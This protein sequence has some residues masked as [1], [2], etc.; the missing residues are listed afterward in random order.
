MGGIVARR[1]DL[2]AFFA[3]LAL[4]ASKLL[5]ANSTARD[6]LERPPSPRTGPNRALA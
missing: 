1:A 6:E 3:L 2:L 5:A 4:L